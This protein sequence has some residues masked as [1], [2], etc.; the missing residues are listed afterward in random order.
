MTIQVT[1]EQLNAL[2][3]GEA[4]MV[5]DPATQQRFAILRELDFA[6]VLEDAQDE[7]LQAGRRKLAA[8]GVK[9]ALEE[10]A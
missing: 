10:P 8:R 6:R 7:R 3:K 9:L 1:P 5:T 4:A 2:A